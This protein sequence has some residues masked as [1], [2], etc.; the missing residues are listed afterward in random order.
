[1][2]RKVYRLIDAKRYASH[3]FDEADS[4]HARLHHS[5][6][7]RIAFGRLSSSSGIKVLT[8]LHAKAM[9]VREARKADSL[10]RAYRFSNPRSRSYLQSLEGSEA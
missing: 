8:L 3:S 4:G 7:M 9:A 5:G 1:M 10:T 6:Q 2:T